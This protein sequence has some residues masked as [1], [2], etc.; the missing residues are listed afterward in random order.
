[1]KG[2][3]S[4]PVLSM[5]FTSVSHITF[6]HLIISGGFSSRKKRTYRQGSAYACFLL[7]RIPACLLLKQTNHSKS[8]TLFTTNILHSFLKQP[9]SILRN[10]QR[11]SIYYFRD[12][13][14]LEGEFLLGCLVIFLIINNNEV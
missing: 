2:K 14:S 3:Y 7:A 8:T 13:I 10:H 6:Y 5:C 11:C 12:G 9:A 1:M 4:N